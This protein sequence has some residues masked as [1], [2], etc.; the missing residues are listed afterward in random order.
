ME[1][2]ISALIVDPDYQNRGIGTEMLRWLVEKCREAK[3]PDIQLFCAKGKR[4][5]YERHGFRAR[6]EDAPGMEYVAV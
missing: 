2:R 1:Q 3:I 4:P 5:F 6:P